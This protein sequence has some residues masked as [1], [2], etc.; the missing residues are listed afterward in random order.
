MKLFRL[1]AAALSAF[2]LLTT[3]PALAQRSPAAAPTG[4]AAEARDLP[5][6]AAAPTGHFDRHHLGRA[7]V[8][9]RGLDREDGDAHSA[10][11]VALVLDDH[12]Q[13]V[14]GARH[15]APQG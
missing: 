9:G 13:Q 2:V 7:H 10:R 4:N 6:P 1:I 15:L 14:V 12:L 11:R 8:Y 5:A 3:A